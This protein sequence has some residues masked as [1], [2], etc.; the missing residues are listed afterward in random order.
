MATKNDSILAELSTRVAARGHELFTHVSD[1]TTYFT[2]ANPKTREVVVKGPI[3]ELDAWLADDDVVSTE[4]PPEYLAASTAGTMSPSVKKAYYDILDALRLL[5]VLTS[6]VMEIRC[7]HSDDV[8]RTM[9]T[10]LFLAL[11]NARKALKGDDGD[12]D[13]PEAA[14]QTVVDTD[15]EPARALFTKLQAKSRRSTIAAVIDELGMYEWEVYEI[16]TRDDV[17]PD[18]YQVS[19]TWT[20][21]GVRHF[22]AACQMLE[23][24]LPPDIREPEHAQ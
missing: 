18:E 24:L 4:D 10:E 7:E 8:A 17:R 16:L 23:N 15:L 1:E 2:V 9:G 5:N 11:E 13:G 12:V 22:L 19:H 6:S 20:E 21:K 14:V 3:R